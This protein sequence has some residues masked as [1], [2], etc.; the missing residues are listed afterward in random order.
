M[1]WADGRGIAAYRNR[2]DAIRFVESGDRD[3]VSVEY[4]DA[5]RPN[6]R[7]LIVRS[8]FTPDRSAISEEWPDDLEMY[9]PVLARV[10]EDFEQLQEQS[11]FGESLWYNTKKNKFVK[12]T[13]TEQHVDAVL[14][15]PGDFGLKKT[16]I[17]KFDDPDSPDDSGLINF[18]KQ[19]GWVRIVAAKQS[20]DIEANNLDQA[21]KAAQAMDKKFIRPKEIILELPKNDFNLLKNNQILAFIKTGKIVQ[22]S[23]VSRFREDVEPLQE[24]SRPK[25]WFDSQ[26]NKL[27]AVKKKDVNHD[28]APINNPKVFGLE[29]SDVEKFRKDMKA[30][31]D[32]IR[33]I[34]K[35]LFARG[36]V[37]TSE[38][39][40]VWF[41]SGTKVEQMAAAARAMSK[42]TLDPDVIVMDV[43][44][45]GSLTP[46]N[47]VTLK[48]NQVKAF[49][50]TGKIV[51]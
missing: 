35:L 30:G 42:K 48:G 51:K 24:A 49:I 12:I 7:S 15:R 14:N 18:M 10:N 9:D 31:F 32:E 29:E 2:A 46:K 17:E 8:K 50:K 25:F 23:Q 40:G 21:S 27:I 13:R 22:L 1:V 26:R 34:K 45:G 20:W 44:A 47:S 16:N 39:L 43:S 36:Y 28:W 11:K 41:M 5:M 33:G 38:S 6:G 37:R 19:K 3:V 4:R